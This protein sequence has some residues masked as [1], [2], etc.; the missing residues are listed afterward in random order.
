VLRLPAIVVASSLIVAG[1]A[2]AQS[3]S[4]PYIGL[5]VGVFS[6]YEFDDQ[7]GLIVDDSTPVY[8]LIGGYQLNENL[9]IEGTLAR[10]GDIE[11]T[12]PFGPPVGTVTARADYELYSV[13]ALGLVPLRSFDF[14]GG[15][16][17][18]KATLKSDVNAP[19]IGL[20]DSAKNDDSGATLLGGVHFYLDRVIIRGEY[21]W[22][23]A[24]KNIDIWDITVG[25][26]FRF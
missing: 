10:T 19:D 23:N 15:V 2:Q 9:A 22:F 6:Y 11:E 1:A 12:F 14:Y 20:A 13:R 26:L 17:Y 7:T 3:D 18:Y 24:D 16:G 21:E 4:G 5:G 8:R 25:V